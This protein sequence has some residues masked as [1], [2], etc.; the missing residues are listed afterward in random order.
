MPISLPM[1]RASWALKLARSVIA[2]SS[3][4][5]SEAISW[6]GSVNDG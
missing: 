1:S 2:F 4:S 3:L 5:T 6:F